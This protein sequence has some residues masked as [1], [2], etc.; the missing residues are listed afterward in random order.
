MAPDRKTTGRRGEDAACEY[1]LNAGHMIIERNWRASHLE[2]DIIT[3]Y[4]DGIHFVEVKTR[5]APTTADPECNVTEQKIKRMTAA[6]R[7]FLLGR[8]S[9]PFRD[10]E[11]FFDV[12]TVIFEGD[13]AEIEYYPQAFIPIYV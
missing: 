3:L 9:A 1:L 11:L 6:A 5:N 13:R 8:D 4:K 2:T 10:A 12:I 7:R